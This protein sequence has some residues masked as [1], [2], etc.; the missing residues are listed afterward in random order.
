MT[1]VSDTPSTIPDEPNV[2]GP[3]EP[4]TH[5]QNEVDSSERGSSEKP[6]TSTAT[7][8]VVPDGSLPEPEIER[9]G[10]WRLLL[11]PPT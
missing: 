8:N 6:Q 1:D 11:V 3:T 4:A 7:T 10:A 2:V 5:A 9:A